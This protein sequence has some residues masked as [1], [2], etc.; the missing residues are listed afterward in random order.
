MRSGWMA[1]SMLSACAGTRSA[2]HAHRAGV[3]MGI[4]WPQ[5]LRSSVYLSRLLPALHTCLPGVVAAAE[6]PLPYC[7]TPGQEEASGVSH[8]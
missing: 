1:S 3:L 5:A 2:A 4:Q 8:P 6:G 7:P